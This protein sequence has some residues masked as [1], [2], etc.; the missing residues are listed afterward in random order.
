MQAGKINVV[1]DGQY[2]SCGKGAVTSALAYRYRPEILSTTNMANAGH[3]VVNVDGEKFVAKALPSA[4]MLHKWYPG[5]DPK[6]M[7]GASAAFDLKQMLFEAQECQASDLLHI[8]H[9]AGIILDKHKEIESQLKGGTKHIA[10]T[11]QGCGAFLAEKVMR[12]PECKLAADYQELSPFV[13]RQYW[14]SPM[15][16]TMALNCML[17]EGDTCLHEGSQGFSLDINH[18]SHYPMCTSRS[19]TAMQN[20]ADMG[21]G[22]YKIG[23]I[24]LV[25]RPYPI[26][27]GNVIEDGKMVGY[28]GG[29]YED[30]KEITWEQVASE[31]GAPPEVTAGELTTVTKRLRRVFTFSEQQLREAVIINGV[32]KI[33]LNFANYIDWSCYGTDDINKLPIKVQKFIDMIEDLVHIPVTFIGTGPQLNHCVIL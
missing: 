23:D 21:V 1:T 27:V 15:S 14:S 24:Y 6:I 12:G 20:I 28:S 11:M 30:Q 5:Y 26:R 4:T 13:N 16:M 18:G 31:A 10:S 33:A 8:H 19:T 17:S 7:V 32:T 25:I 22:P 3:T 29:C 9:R 2:G